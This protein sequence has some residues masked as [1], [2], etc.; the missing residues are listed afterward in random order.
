MSALRRLRDAAPEFADATC[1]AIACPAC[2]TVELARS[3]AGYVTTVIN[4]T[5]IVP[6]ISRGDPHSVSVP[7]QA[8]RRHTHSSALRTNFPG[9]ITNRGV[10][11]VQVQQMPCG[12]MW[13]G[14]PG[15]RR[16]GLTCAATSLCA[17]WRAASLASALPLCGP[18][19][20]WLPRLSGSCMHAFQASLLLL[21]MHSAMNDVCRLL[22]AL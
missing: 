11:G 4:S 14:A 3:C 2:M 8:L 16:S 21:C 6:T 9:T 7:T 18:R 12:R 1:L 15:M 5:D 20:G 13:Y 19:Q 10:M 22:Y 17:L